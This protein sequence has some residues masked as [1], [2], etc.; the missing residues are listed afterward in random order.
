MGEAEDCISINADTLP[1]GITKHCP[2]TR[3]S[4]AVSSLQ[5][6]K[7]LPL[8]DGL[9]RLDSQMGYCSTVM[10]AILRTVFPYCI[11]LMTVD[12]VGGEG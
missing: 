4:A 11:L 2:K 1:R 12:A 9:K 8:N 10:K 7:E 5:Q 6:K 3:A